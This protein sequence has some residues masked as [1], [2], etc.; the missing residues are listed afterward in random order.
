[1][2]MRAMSTAAFPIRSM[3]EITWSTLDICSASCGERAARMHTSRISC[4][5][6]SRRSSSSMTSSAMATLSKNS[7]A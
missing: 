5:S 6:P 3:D 7:A 1:M 2:T 4:T